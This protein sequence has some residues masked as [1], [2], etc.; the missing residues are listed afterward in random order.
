MLFKF[1][2]QRV[3]FVGSGHNVIKTHAGG[4]GHVYI[5]KLTYVAVGCFAVNT[6]LFEMRDY[7]YIINGTEEE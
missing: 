7:I 3:V 2:A 1:Y 4:S 5:S 6:R